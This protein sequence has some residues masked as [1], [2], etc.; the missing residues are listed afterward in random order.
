M[1]EPWHRPRSFGFASCGS[2]VHQASCQ[3]EVEIGLH[4]ESEGPAALNNCWS[5]LGH[6]CLIQVT[7]MMPRPASQTPEHLSGLGPSESS[8]HHVGVLSCFACH[9]EPF[10]TI[11]EGGLGWHGQLGVISP[12]CSGQ[13]TIQV[14]VKGRKALQV[15]LC[16]RPFRQVAQSP[17]TPSQWMMLHD[18]CVPLWATFWRWL[19]KSNLPSWPRWA[20]W[21]VSPNRAPVVGCHLRAL[22]WMTSWLG[23]MSM[24]S[25][26]SAAA[27]LSDVATSSAAVG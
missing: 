7:G 5:S 17:F 6:G 8:C 22:W 24:A 11:I 3:K 26:S 27:R 13:E 20:G 23:P 21:L 15:L 2:P 14:R 19:I 4:P 9:L 10:R 16:S 1:E 12:F 25:R 18:A